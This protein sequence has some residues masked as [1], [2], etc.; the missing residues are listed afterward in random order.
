MLL[1]LLSSQGDAPVVPTPAAI[2]TF[3]SQYSDG[4]TFLDGSEGETR[5]TQQ[6]D[7][8]MIAE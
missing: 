2:P 8:K 7:G 5:T 1:L 6:S 3:V 4:K